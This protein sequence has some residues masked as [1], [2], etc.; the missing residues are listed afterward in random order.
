MQALRSKTNDDMRALLGDDRMKTFET[1]R[2]Q[3]GGDGPGRGMGWGRPGF[4]P[5]GGPNPADPGAN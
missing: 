2:R 1:M 4:P 3:G 5:G